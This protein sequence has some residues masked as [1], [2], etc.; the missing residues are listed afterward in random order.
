MRSPAKGHRVWSDEERGKYRA[1]GGVGEEN[2]ASEAFDSYEVSR[3]K[4]KKVFLDVY[5]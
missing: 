3:G 4:K 5:G 1:L 2:P